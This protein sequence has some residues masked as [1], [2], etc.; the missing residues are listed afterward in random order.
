[1]PRMAFEQM[2]HELVG[3]KL[4]LAAWLA[5][6]RPILQGLEHY[7][8]LGPANKEEL[9]QWYGLSR[10]NELLIGGVARELPH[11]EAH[12]RQDV[13][14]RDALFQFESLVNGAV[15]KISLADYR[16]FF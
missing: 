2:F 1:M 6:A 13:Q 9:C 7:R 16:R 4:E 3:G 14:R 15:P 10:V 5:T 12:V 11:R 8:R